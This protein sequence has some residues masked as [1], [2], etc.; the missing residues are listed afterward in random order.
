MLDEADRLLNMDF[1]QE[2]D[3][4]LK[5]IPKVSRPLPQ[6]G[7]LPRQLCGYALASA[8]APA[9]VPELGSQLG[10]SLWS[11]TRRSGARSCSVPP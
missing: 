7:W 2:I 11:R 6:R 4:I 8:A 10:S 5:V 3:Q 1:E 9:P